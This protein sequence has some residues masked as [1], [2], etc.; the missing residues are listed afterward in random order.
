MDK[1][2]LELEI[3]M[4]QGKIKFY[5]LADHKDMIPVCASWA[6]G[7]WGCQSGGSIERAIN[8]FSEGANK[9][10]IPMT[11]VAMMD[12]KPAGMA[13]LWESDCESKLH[14]SPWLASLYVHPFYRGLGIASDLV[15]KLEKES[16]NLGYKHLYLV[17]EDAGALYSKL[18]WTKLEDA[19][20]L[21][22]NALIME[23]SLVFSE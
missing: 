1:G 21:H 10:K 13:S 20:T 6:Y 19:K 16:F 4:E 3:L 12:G 11:L 7:R 18:G 9:K 15:K 17:T 8:R 5:H 22:G 2:L 14:L 23:K